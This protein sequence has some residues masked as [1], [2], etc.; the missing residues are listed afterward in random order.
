MKLTDILIFDQ[1]FYAHRSD[2]KEKETLEEHSERC[3]SYFNRIVS[4]K[5]MEK[6]LQNLW[7]CYLSSEKK[8][9]LEFCMSLLEYAV[10]FHDT[11]KINPEYQRLKMKN[12]E[13]GRP[14]EFLSGAN[15][16]L[17][18]AVIYMDFCLALIEK[19]GFSKADKKLM[20]GLICLNGYVISRH[21]SDL[22]DFQGF[23]DNFSENGAA[24]A[25]VA[26]IETSGLIGYG[27][28]QYLS[29]ET[30][31]KCVRFLKNAMK[32]SSRKQQICVFIYTRLA[33]SLLVAADYYATT[34][35]Q[36]G[37]KIEQ[38]GD[39][40][41]IEELKAAYE[42]APLTREI[43][44]YEKTEYGKSADFSA[45][46]SI[47]TLR[48]ELF[49]DVEKT[50]KAE[51][52][53]SVYFLEAPT[54]SG[55]SN[56]AMNL[57]FQMLGKTR[58]KLFYIYPFNTLVEQNIEILEKLFGDR[59]EIRQKIA[60]VNSITPIKEDNKFD[61]DSAAFYQKTLLDRQFLNYPFILSTHV[62]LFRMMFGR[63]KAD[64][65]G[66]MQL[67]NSVIVLDEIQS[68]KNS[69]W[70]E[71]IIFLKA[72]SELLNMKVIIMSATLPD[73]AYLTGE[74]EDIVRLM[75]DRDKYFSNP[76]FRERVQVSYELLDRQ[77]S[78]EDLWNHMDAQSRDKKLLIEFIRKTSA[79]EFFRFL[80][81]ENSDWKLFLITGDD[82]QTER[83]QILRQ[84]GESSQTAMILVATQ[85]IEAGVDLD[86]DIGYKDISKLDSE[87]QFLGRINRSCKRDGKA[88]FFDFDSADKI[89]GLDIRKNLEFTLKSQDMQNILRE[90]NFSQY[91][92]PVLRQLKREWNDSKKD[93]VRLEDFFDQWV[94]H[95]QF[96]KIEE[97]MELID[98]KDWTISVFM[99]RTIAL[100]DGT[101]LEGAACWQRYKDL[102]RDQEMDYAKKQYQLSQAR[103]QMSYFIYEVSMDQNNVFAY[104]DR[105]GELYYIEDGETYFENGKLNTE[106][107]ARE[108]GL[109]L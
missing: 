40:D 66:F 8:E 53:A 27:G 32:G 81:K 96:S 54:G 6:P 102:L 106:K 92:E 104:N 2:E 36:T 97:R 60:V 29:E 28:L 93:D 44:R 108:G 12:E 63:D 4:E 89:Y 80:Q 105:I 94:Q 22:A 88:F 20:K 73:L 14:C 82:N 84:I 26:G 30:A 78:Y 69:I 85:V 76:K 34:E 65:F 31:G 43:R 19:S 58:R 45:S 35:Y 46:E 61:E 62:S 100:E 15:H 57:S 11:G 25:I 18:S 109:F 33:Y 67:A 38:F 39:L 7:S 42:A 59:Q 16:S 9:L 83:K 24:E 10:L 5:K 55:K 72:F 17:L 47:N 68:Y 77:L 90:K 71:I 75:K 101:M 86:M 50:W 13:A 52:D 41:Q 3:H 51:P 1:P 21:H 64:V 99:N 91:Y 98:D 48:S 74:S 95:L 37:V 87:E 70:S 49:L 103:S 23:L 79:Y 107:F 56:T